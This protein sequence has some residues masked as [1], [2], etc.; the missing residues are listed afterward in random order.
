MNVGNPDFTPSRADFTSLSFSQAGQPTLAFEDWANGYK[1]S[2]MKFDGTNWVNVGNAGFSPGEALCT[3]LAFSPSGEPTVAFDD[4]SAIHK[5]IVM[6]Y[7]GTNWVYVGTP[8][9]SAG[10]AD[11]T[12]LAFSLS[13]QPYV[14]YMDF[15]NS[16]KATVM[17][18]DGTNWVVAGSPG[19]STEEAW[20]I[21]LAFSPSGD[22]YVAF[23][24]VAK[25][26]VMKFNGTNWVYVGIP[27]FSAG[28]APFTSLAFSP[29]GQPYVAYE[30]IT[31]GQKVTVMRYDGS[32]WVNVGNP[33]FSAGHAG[34]TS[35][36]FNTSG[37]PYVSFSDSINLWKATVMSFNG[38]S[39]GNVG[40]AGFSAG[41]ANYPSLAISSS[42]KPYVG[43]GDDAYYATVM[44]YDTVCYVG[45]AGPI[46]GPVQVCAGVSGYIYSVAPIL[47]A[48]SYSWSVPPGATIT[49]GAGT[50]TITVSY[51]I[52]A[53]SGYISVNGT[54]NCTG[55]SSQLFVN[56][57]APPV[58]ALTGNN[59]VCSGTTGVVYT[60]QAG[61]SNYLWSVS[62][63]GIITAGGT[64]IDNTVTVTWNTAGLQTI[65]INY[66]DSLGCSA[67]HPTIFYVTVNA[68]PVPAINGNSIVC[69]GITG[70][71][72]T[73]QTGM[74]DYSWNVSSGGTITAGGTPSSNSVTVTWNIAGAQSVSV[75][76]TDTNGC[77][78]L[79]PVVYPVTVTPLP[80]AAGPIT[81]M[82]PVC[83]GVQGI[84]YSIADV[85]FASTYLW[86]TPSG[87]DIVSGQNTTSV[88]VNFSQ[89]ASSGDFIVYPANTCGSGP[90]SPP[91][92]VIVSHTAS[93]SAGPDT[94]VC[95]GTIITIHQATAS[96]QTSLRW[97]TT[98]QG[99]ISGDT[100][101][102][103]S[104][105]PSAADT[106]DVILTLT[107]VSAFPCMSDSSSMT[108]HYGLHPVAYAGPDLTVCDTIP[109]SPE[110][111]FALHYSS[112]LWTTT[113]SGQLSNPATLTPTYT[114]SPGE[115]GDVILIL[116]AQGT[117]SCLHETAEDTMKIMIY[118]GVRIFAAK[119]DT[120]PYD[121]RDTLKVA[122]SGGS[123]SYLY[124]WYPGSLLINDTIRDPVT[125]NLVSDTVFSLLVKDRITGCAA[126]G[127]IHVF[128]IRTEIS[129][130]CILVH[131]V[132]TPNGDGLNDYLFID[133]IENFPRNNLEIFNRWG[134]EITSITGYDNKTHIWAATGKNG[135]VVPD[136]TYYYLLHIP[137]AKTLTGWI[138]VRGH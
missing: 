51:G 32:A 124:T 122:I 56:V 107:V 128:L 18:Y 14:A 126:T 26:S 113:G 64:S 59:S 8:G 47:G 121:S 27:G 130:D 58:P 116:H 109:V 36:A 42:G 33:G 136:G 135:R 78:A 11:Y 20:Y 90:P 66:T 52:T 69:E 91:F 132:V 118:P 75:N 10:D 87:V 17:K 35:L 24:N 81:G 68:L 97:S 80:L 129:E 88:I 133:C 38:T 108:I 102:S 65:S 110:G 84:T 37:T 85:P 71:I 79:H 134:D 5:A 61:M 23:G 48:Y 131:N 22:P 60:T 1:A 30:D 76:Y 43:Y 25:A 41:E 45:P 114:P 67:L 100:T 62:A 19:F 21:S 31:N 127:N 115:S 73:T 92:H 15:A 138:L 72:Y 16:F 4:Y 98:G 50:T 46:T 12:S 83:A 106:G 74:T 86:T 103:P 3:S 6:K 9:F 112:I 34:F 40:I 2:V 77:T 49:S 94:S 101:L 105:T 119:N 29:A 39:W 117:G 123:G 82:T 54:S 28:G 13:G 99:T 57:N 96:D 93:V 104:Y 70:V 95:E 120:I 53:S 111:A 63:G 137:N 44:K 89:T 125:V 55:T 7:N